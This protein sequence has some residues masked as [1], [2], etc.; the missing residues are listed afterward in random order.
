MNSKVCLKIALLGE[1]LLAVWPGTGEGALSGMDSIVLF[2]AGFLREGSVAARPITAEGFQ[3]VASVGSSVLRQIGFRSTGF[4]T[5]RPVT[6]KRSLSSVDPH[7]IIQ[8]GFRTKCS[9]ACWPIAFVALLLLMSPSDVDS[10][11]GLPGEGLPTIWLR[12]FD[13][14]IFSSRMC[15]QVLT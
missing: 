6:T 2:K 15:R 14:T 11:T 7:M 13:K 8:I 9:A 5:S 1:H 10:Q 4:L 3:F 12:A